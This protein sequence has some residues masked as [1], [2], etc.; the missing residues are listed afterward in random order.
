MLLPSRWS[1]TSLNF[2]TA[3]GE[4]VALRRSRRRQGPTPAGCVQPAG[5][6][7]ERSRRGTWARARSYHAVGS[8]PDLVDVAAADLE[9]GRAT[10]PSR[11]E[12]FNTRGAVL[13]FVTVWSERSDWSAAR[14][15]SEVD[16]WRGGGNGHSSG[17]RQH[18]FGRRLRTG[19]AGAIVVGGAIFMGGAASLSDGRSRT[20]DLSRHRKTAELDGHGFAQ[21]RCEHRQD[22][23][24]PT[25]PARLAIGT[26]VPLTA[27]T[28][29]FPSGH[30]ADGDL[31]QGSGSSPATGTVK[32]ATAR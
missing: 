29:H 10:R 12:R 17:S 6:R 8:T 19:A 2:A 26:L 7:P 24:S 5:A 22:R 3:G 30:G 4:A 15:E 18:S 11:I 25:I 20:P 9:N 23:G 32:L 14:S 1:R 31:D 28:K 13:P 21:Q 16:R 27:A